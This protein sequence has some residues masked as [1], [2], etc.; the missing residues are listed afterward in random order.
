MSIGPTPAVVRRSLREFGEHLRTWR[1]LQ[2]LT[3]DQVADRAGIGVH[4]VR[5]L[6]TG[7]GASLENTM[8]VVRALGM[9]PTFTDAIDPY[10][11]DV[12]RLRSEELLPQRVRKREEP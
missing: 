3:L 1:K 4:T 11:T 7:Q 10:L 8:R 12:G 6:E 5:R 9:L 2:R